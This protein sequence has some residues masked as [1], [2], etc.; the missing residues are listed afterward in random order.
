LY[1]V[2]IIIHT[3]CPYCIIWLFTFKAAGVF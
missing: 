1:S 2:L 3:V